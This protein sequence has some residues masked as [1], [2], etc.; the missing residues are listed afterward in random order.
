MRP[1]HFPL[2]YVGCWCG[3]NGPVEGVLIDSFSPL[4]FSLTPV[5]WVACSSP[6]SPAASR[7]SLF[8]P[9]SLTVRGQVAGRVPNLGRDHRWEV[10][11]DRTDISEIIVASD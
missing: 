1:G 3:V 5:P 9:R 2:A 11:E 7:V 10:E 8:P 6:G 4:S